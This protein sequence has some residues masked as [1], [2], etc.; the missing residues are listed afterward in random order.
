MADTGDLTLS[1]APR[2]RKADEIDA[3][4]EQ[5]H[6][7]VIEVVPNADVTFKVGTGEDAIDVKVL[8]TAMGLASPVLSRMLFGQF[9]EAET[10]VVK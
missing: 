8:G 7:K 4:E 1:C 3:A 10:K 5:P 6:S 2:K 9:A